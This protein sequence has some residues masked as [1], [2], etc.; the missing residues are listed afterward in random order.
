MKITLR[1]ISINQRLSE[2]TLAFAA[3]VVVD[4]VDAFD[5]SNHGTGGPDL[6]RKLP[7]YNGPD[8]AVI[9]AWLEEN[10]TPVDVD[11][12]KLEYDLELKV[13]ELLEEHQARKRL[14]KTLRAK[15]VVI[16]ESD[17]K[18]A[19]FSYKAPPT[20]ENIA[21]IRRQTTGIIVNGDSVAYERAVELI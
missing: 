7:G 4:G 21:R 1:K 15:V 14:D 8:V 16:E 2:E 9:D 20:P 18:D 19:L 11:G 13:A 6:Y 12:M 5:A 10:T 3:I 17:G